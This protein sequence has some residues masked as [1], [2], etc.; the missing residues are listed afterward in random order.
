MK[1]KLPYWVLPPTYEGTAALAA[2]CLNVVAFTIAA[3]ALY[4]M[5]FYL[6]LSHCLDRGYN[7]S[8]C[9]RLA[10][11]SALLFC[12]NPAGVFF[13]AAYSESIFSMLTFTGHAIIASAPNMTYTPIRLFIATLLWSM[14]SYGRSNG[15]LSA[16]WLAITGLSRIVR[17]WTDTNMNCKAFGK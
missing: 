13:T 8:R 1:T 16:V 5:T 12:I 9:E 17:L 7:M 14:A 6:T 3:L 10:Q 11:L 15:T 2:L 4:L